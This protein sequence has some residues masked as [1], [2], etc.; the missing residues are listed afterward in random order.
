MKKSLSILLALVLSLH[1]AVPAL[2]AQAP[3]FSDVPTGH[4]AYAYVRQA[5]Q[6]G[7]VN[8]VGNG[9]FLPEGTLTIAEFT[10]M[11]LRALY[12]EAP[13]EQ[14][15]GEVGEWYAPYTAYAYER[16]LYEATSVAREM[17]VCPEGGEAAFLAREMDWNATRYDMAAMLYWA[18]EAD[19]GEEA[20][21][22]DLRWAEESAREAVA[23]WEQVPARYQTLVAFCFR[24]GILAGMDERGT[25]QGTGTVTRAQAAAMLCRVLDRSAQEPDAPVPETPEETPSE[26]PEYDGPLMPNGQPLT[27]ENVHAL[28]GG[29]RTEY[30]EGMHWTNENSYT[31]HALA[32]NGF[33]CAAFALLCSDKAFG[34]LPSRQHS[35]F[36]DIRVGDMLRV[37]GDTHSVVVLE[38]KADSVIVAEG[39]YADTIHWDREITRESLESDR[40]FYVETRYPKDA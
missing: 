16:D 27:E 34:D 15:T 6:A 10:A 32:I 19:A 2:A 24:S 5:A 26:E 17:A 7:V 3:E 18:L 23:D 29:L 11:L 33:G 13:V 21:A 9:R 35:K 8:G 25:F 30:P 39:N 40:Q 31:S 4:W 38:K 14:Y 37:R 28:I 22:A 20:L 1:L 36:D 12:G